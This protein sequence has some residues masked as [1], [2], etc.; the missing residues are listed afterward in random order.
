METEYCHVTQ[1]ANM[2]V[3]FDAAQCFSTIFDHGQ[4]KPAQRLHVTHIA[5]D[6]R[7][8]D[9]ACA[10]GHSIGHMFGINAVGTGIHVHKHWLGAQS[11]NGCCCG[12][13]IGVGQDHFVAYANAQSLQRYVQGARGAAGGYAVISAAPS[14]KLRFKSINPQVEILIPGMLHGL[15]NIVSFKISDAGTRNWYHR[16]HTEYI[17]DNMLTQEHLQQLVGPQIRVAA[18][19]DL[20]YYAPNMSALYADLKAYIQSRWPNGES[21][22]EPHERLVFW[23]DDLDVI[24]GDQAVPFTLYNLQLVLRELRISNWFVRVITKLP[25]YQV[26]ADRVAAM[27]VP[28]QP[29]KCIDGS[30]YGSCIC[31]LP[32]PVTDLGYDPGID[33]RRLDVSEVEWPFLVQSRQG[34]FHRTYFVSQ[35]LEHG[36]GKSGIVAYHNIKDV[37]HLEANAA[38]TDCSAVF[39]TT[40]PFHRHSTEYVI[41]DHQRRAQVDAF[42]SVKNYFHAIPQQDV[43]SA[44]AV[45]GYSDPTINQAAINVAMET[46]ANMPRPFVTAITFKPITNLRPFVVLAP[47]NTLAFLRDLGFQTFGDFWD[48]SYDIMIRLEDRV[49]A[50]LDILKQWSAMS[51][52]QIRQRLE[53]M[54]G[55][56]EYNHNHY[57][58]QLVQQQRQH[59]I[60]GMQ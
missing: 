52:Q 43:K 16:G 23:H 40:Q 5:I 20:V 41:H 53:Q 33:G 11:R 21:N 55:V 51:P 60:Q 14:S 10:A 13:P 18:F 49:A 42:L 47:T 34:R 30:I 4:I 58:T 45:A 46:T 12:D 6:M 32:Y 22:F 17:L 37:Y 50:V 3:A 19:F 36:L 59:L 54:R 31:N 44:I 48:E 25:N 39:L 26:F 1:L 29:I 28:D 9:G 35:L 56:L 24:L 27:L 2:P 38:N 57:C 8:Y 7:G 15:V